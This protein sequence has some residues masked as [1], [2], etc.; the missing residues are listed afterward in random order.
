MVRHS[1][2]ETSH[3]RDEDSNGKRAKETLLDLVSTIRS[4]KEHNERLMRAHAEQ[5]KLNAIL[6]QSLL[7]IQKHLQ[8]GLAISNVGL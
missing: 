2:E 4:L 5:I 6:L 8:Q 1:M 7:E 3:F